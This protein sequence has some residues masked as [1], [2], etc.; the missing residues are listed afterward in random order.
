MCMQAN[1]CRQAHTHARMHERK[2]TGNDRHRSHGERDVER[3]K[4]GIR[5]LRYVV[6]VVAAVVVSKGSAQLCSMLL[7]DDDDDR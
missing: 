3:A 6:V 4:E 5:S 7:H 2:L 1:T